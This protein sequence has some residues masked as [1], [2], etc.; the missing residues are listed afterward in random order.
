M[1]RSLLLMTLAA[2]G[3]F[4]ACTSVYE[5]TDGARLLQ[6]LNDRGF[7]KR[8]EGDVNEEYY[9]GVGDVLRIL[10]LGNPELTIPPTSVQSDGTISLPYIDRVHV[11]GL[12][13][14]DIANLLNEKYSR[15]FRGLNLQVQVAAT[16]SKRIYLFGQVLRKGAL[17][18]SGDTTIVEILA[19]VQLSDLAHPSKIHI[20]RADPREPL[21]IRFSLSDFVTTGNSLY[22]IQLQE[23]DVIYV[24][25][26]YLG[27]VILFF[28]RL[29]RP[30]R[31]LVLGANAIRLATVLEAELENLQDLR[32]RQVGFNN[33]FLIQEP[34]AEGD[35][36]K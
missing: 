16:P 23:N 32:D 9:V 27:Y 26:T 3:L 25:P 13:P 33:N 6:E 17:P 21:I 5:T 30:L 22:N 28:E 29:L 35:D 7:G 34:K 18:F 20:I 19:L 10:E 31:S 36:E 8:Y 1:R 11:G 14:E 2:S 12:T 24:E 4:G 15:F